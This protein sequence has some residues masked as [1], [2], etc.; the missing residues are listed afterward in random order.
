MTDPARARLL[1]EQQ[2]LL[3]SLDDL[4]A[5]LAAGDLDAHDYEQLR[6]DYVARTAEVT[7]ALAGAD[8]AE[9]RSGSMPWMARLGWSLVVLTVAAAGTWAMIEFSGARGSGETATG[10]IRQSTASLLSEAAAEFGR[11]DPERAIELYG[12]VLEL[13]PSNVEARTY[14]GWVRYQAG[15]VESALVDFDEV[16][17]FDPGYPDVRVFLSIAALDREEYATAAAELDAFDANNPSPVARQLVDQRQLRE[18]IASGLVLD[19]LAASDGRL[20]LE[21]AGIE[22]DQAQLA[23]ETLVRFGQ[24]ADALV[25]FD[26]VLDRQPGHAPALAWRGWTLALTAQ[27]GVEELF[28]DAE[29]W[30]DDAVAADPRYPD[31]RVFRAFL[32]RRLDR[33]DEAAVELAAFDALEVQPADMLALIEEYDL[34]SVLD[35]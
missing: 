17:A 27:A 33:V 1:E 2:H 21:A 34:R 3:R 15:D 12:D 31:A 9:R 18:R 8:V 20:D 30:L 6:D 22:V 35:Q 4:D 28:V 19:A 26:A 5:E 25:V 13:Q 29:R 10:E 14:R 7:R 24:P 23:G 32:Y 11:G 16:V